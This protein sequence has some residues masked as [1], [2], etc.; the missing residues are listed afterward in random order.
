MPQVI[1]FRKNHGIWNEKN[2]GIRCEAFSTNLSTFWS[3]LYATNGL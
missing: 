1:N 2:Q 3:P